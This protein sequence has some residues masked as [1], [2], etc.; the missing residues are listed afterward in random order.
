ML[1]F[2]FIRY[3]NFESK[4]NYLIHVNKKCKG[5]FTKTFKDENEFVRWYV[6]AKPRIMMYP[7]LISQLNSRKEAMRIIY[8][9]DSYIIKYKKNLYGIRHGNGR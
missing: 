7:S 2:S 4:T 9:L 1:T 6:N 5:S 8:K 3:G